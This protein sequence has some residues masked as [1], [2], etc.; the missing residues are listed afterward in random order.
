M[1]QQQDTFAKS[2][3][4]SKTVNTLTDPLSLV[5][6][7]KVI[8]KQG[9]A[10]DDEEKEMQF[11]CLSVPLCK[12]NELI[13]VLGLSGTL[14]ELKRSNISKLVKSLKQVGKEIEL[15]LLE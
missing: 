14:S 5:S 15:N 6:A 13:A 11:R 1:S 3:F 12:N 8:R 10:L 2:N 7:L 4:E 9:Y